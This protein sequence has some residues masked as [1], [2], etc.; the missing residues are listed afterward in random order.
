MTTTEYSCQTCN[1]SDYS[2]GQY[3]RV[4]TYKCE[5]KSTTVVKSVATGKFKSVRVS[6]KKKQIRE[7]N[8][9]V[10]KWK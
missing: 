2:S 9:L 3:E 7:L 5:N 6:E 4:K 1:D 10:S 8:K